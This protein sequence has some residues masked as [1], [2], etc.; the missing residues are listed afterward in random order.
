MAQLDPR[1]VRLY[2]PAFAL[3]D[4]RDVEAHVR[5]LLD[6]Q[7]RTWG[8]RLDA[9]KYDDALAYLVALCWRLS[10]LQGD[11][12]TAR[13]EHAAEIYI[14]D[15]VDGLTQ[16]LAPFP[17]RARAEAAVAI[18]LLR[19]CPGA[20][21]AV[22]YRE[23]RPAG[24]YDPRQGLSF[25]T[26]SRRI[27]SRRVVDWY[28]HTFGDSRYGGTPKP[29]SLDRLV[30]EWERNDG[31]GVDESYLDRSG[32]GARLDFIDELNRH[33]YVDPTEEVLDRAAIAR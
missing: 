4:V 32:P 30:D 7:L 12:R 31:S 19:H 15:D 13:V 21:V 27:L 20:I 17:T 23:Q 6:A 9:A 18:W 3:W 10:G 2:G 8:A 28:R 14:S 29:L 22:S 5:T 11:G 1:H 16:T 26:Y 24:A 25:S 33:A